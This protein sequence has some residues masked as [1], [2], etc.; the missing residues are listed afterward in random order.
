MWE[1]KRRTTLQKTSKILMGVGEVMRP[2]ALQAKIYDDD[3]DDMMYSF[4]Y[5]TPTCFNFIT[6]ISQLT[7][8]LH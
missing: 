2:E 7:P 6:I 8:N 3:D 4:Y 1:T 5:L